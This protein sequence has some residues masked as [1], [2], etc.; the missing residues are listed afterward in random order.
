MKRNVI[1]GGGSAGLTTAYYLCKAGRPVV[2]IEREKNIGGLARS[3]HY[4]G[5]CFDIGPHRFYS[6]NPK[7]N[8]FLQEVYGGS[9]IVLPRHSMVYFMNR[10][11]E[12]PLRLSTIPK[13]PL[14]ISVCAG[15]DMITKSGSLD[16]PGPSFKDYILRRYGKTLY[17]H[18]FKDYTEKFIGIDT[19]D[20]HRNWARTGLERAAIDENVNTA[21]LF[22]IFKMMLKPKVPEL[23]FLYPK[24]NGICAFWEA[25]ARKIKEMGGEIITASSVDSISIKED[26][27]GKKS[28]DRLYAGGSEIECESLTWSASVND[29]AS[30]LNLPPSGLDYR[31]EIICA[32][33]LDRPPLQT[34]QWCYYGDKDLIFSR[35]SNPAGFAPSC[36]PDGKGAL[37]LEITC[38]YEDELWRD[39]ER[40]MPKLKEQLDKTGVLETST[41]I[42]DFKMEKIREA[43]PIY[44]IDYIERMNRFEK[45]CGEFKNLRL[46]GRTGRFWYNNMDHSIENAI[47]TA[48]ELAKTASVQA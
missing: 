6:N 48:E 16:S 44:R 19:E 11:H 3:F 29:L 24:E 30:K 12:W 4:N 46:L 7:V 31:A 2:V 22:E 23:N 32:V 43:Y 15:I 38:Q 40:M 37:C 21:S 14:H 42:E 33:M 36:V 26:A 17:T 9:F 1:I 5:W 35:I 25:C 28:I 8:S 41:Q 18:F 34:A 39:P 45:E 10:Y 47:D 13:L 27:D 20:T